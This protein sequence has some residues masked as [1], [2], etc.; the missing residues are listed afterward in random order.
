MRFLHAPLLLKVFLLIA[1]LLLLEAPKYAPCVPYDL[2]FVNVYVTKR[3][4][5]H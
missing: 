4:H 3:I 1:H 2:V 5:I